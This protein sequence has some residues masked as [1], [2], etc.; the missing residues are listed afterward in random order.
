M[1]SG[2]NNIVFIVDFCEWG[3][4]IRKEVWLFLCV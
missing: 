1:E 4:D 2:W 3:I